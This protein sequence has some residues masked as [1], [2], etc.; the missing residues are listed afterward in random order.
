VKALRNQGCIEKYDHTFLGYN[1]RLDALQAAVLSAKLPYLDSWNELRRQIA[2]QYM[3]QLKNLPFHLPAVPGTSVPVW[4][5]FVIQL[6][7]GDR[8]AFMSFLKEKGVA[9][10]IHYPVALHQ[11]PSLSFLGYRVGAFPVA[12]ALASQCVSL[13]MY[14]GMTTEQVAHVVDSVKSYFV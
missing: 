2:E 7:D 9:T 13:P 14:P 5:L 4:H 11:T 8:E 12:E 6:L 1:G 10:G 3:S